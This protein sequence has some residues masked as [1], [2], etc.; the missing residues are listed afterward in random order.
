LFGYLN[1][2]GSLNIQGKKNL[3][4]LTMERNSHEE[5]G[6]IKLLNNVYIDYDIYM[7]KGLHEC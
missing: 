7:Q 6:L 4:S 5:N 2:C 1:L 3:K